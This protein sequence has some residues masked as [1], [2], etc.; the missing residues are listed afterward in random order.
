MMVAAV[1]VP[2][3]VAGGAGTPCVP[4]GGT[5][6]GLAQRKNETPPFTDRWPK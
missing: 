2:L 3:I 1:A 4:A 6:G 5:I